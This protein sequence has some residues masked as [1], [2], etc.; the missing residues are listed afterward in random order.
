M[1]LTQLSDMVAT[2]TKG[3]LDEHQRPHPRVGRRPRRRAA[4]HVRGPPPGEVQGHRAQRRAPSPTAPTCGSST[5]GDPERRPQR[6]RGPPARGIR[7]GPDASTSCARAATTST[8]ACSTCRPTAC[9]ARSTS[10][11]CPASRPAVR[12][13]D[14]QGRSRSRMLRAYNDWHIDE[15]CGATRAASS[16]S[17]SRRSGTPSAIADEV[18]RV[19]EKG[20]HAITFPE[21]PVPLGY[22]SLHTDHWDPFWQACSDEGTSCACTSARRGS[23]RSPRSTRRST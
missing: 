20:C 22:P 11:R 17:R 19:A 9:S 18:R 8:S 3:A 10:R 13:V 5:P 1:S 4:R 6:G 2:V 7:H 21:N 23:S 14:G 16:R 15:W 12:R